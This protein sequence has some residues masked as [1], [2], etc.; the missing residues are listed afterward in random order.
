MVIY[1]QPSQLLYNNLVWY[2]SPWAYSADTGDQL[3]CVAIRVTPEV[4]PCASNVDNP[5]FQ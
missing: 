1:Q 2:I 4:Y 3:F 5:I